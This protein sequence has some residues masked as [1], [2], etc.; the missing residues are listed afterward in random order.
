[1]TTDPTTTPVQATPVVV[2]YTNRDFYSLRDDLITRVKDRV[3]VG[4]TSKWYGNDPADFGVAL[5][6]SFAYMGDIIG[7]YIDR[8]AN[9]SNILTATQR[10]SIY[11][12]AIA[13]GYTP[14]GY[15]SATCTVQFINTT[16]NLTL[17]P[18]PVGTQ[19]SGSIVDGDTTRRVIFTT[20]QEA[21]FTSTKSV[22][23]VT[24]STPGSGYVQY[25][26]DNSSG[27]F[28]A[29]HTVT[30]TGVSPSGYNVTA[31]PIVSATSTAIVVA[32]A[33]TG[34]ATLSSAS[35]L[36]YVSPVSVTAEHGEYVSLRDGNA[37][38]PLISGDVAG[39][40][41]GTSDGTPFQSFRLKD[42]SVVQG[43]VS[44]QVQSG[45][46]YGTWA[47]VTHLM[48]YGPADSVYTVYTDSNNNTY[49]R[50]GDGVSGAIPNMYSKIKVDYLSGG[51]TI[52]NIPV[53]TLTQVSKAPG[54]SNLSPYISNLTTSNTTVGTGGADPESLD[55]IRAN[56]P[57]VAATNSR[58][59]T[60]ADYS[61]LALG[62]D[63]VGKANATSS[64]WSSVTLYVAPRRD[65]N[66][67]DVYPG[68][69]DTNTA[70]T[71]EWT[72]IQ[73]DVQ[74]YMA[75][76]LQI[77]VSLTI[78]A[79]TY[80]DVSLKMSYSK[81]PEFSATQVE[82]SIKS[83]LNSYYSYYVATFAQTI[84]PEDIEFLLK[85]VPGIYNVRVTSLVRSGESDLRGTLVGN[86]GE[87]F[88]FKSSNIVL[89]ALGT[90]ATLAAL[91][92]TN[93]STFIPTFA[94]GTLDY[95]TTLTSGTSTEIT[96]TP[97]STSGTVVRVSGG[98]QTNTVTYADATSAPVTVSIPVGTT[99]F[100]IVVTAEDGTT[101]KTYTL[102]VTRA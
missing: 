102:T 45:T 16:A 21:D 23:A 83:Y 26:L 6:E 31:E 74:T 98:G 35:A 62:V 44:V 10:N 71:S 5:I 43:T 48:D 1:M 85:Y 27:A 41:V 49:V 39:E 89:T 75:D 90:T 56:A 8:I 14:S 52:G 59:I 42:S 79:P 78:A 18:L 84:Y 65:I 55:S 76:K 33:T 2:D 22:T 80:S 88:I 92:A 30:I 11:N 86:P 63:T 3:N 66:S 69:N 73:S 9:E 94:S 77:G 34:T 24:P 38:D 72:S 97:T 101:T 95:A 87:I 20:T 82:D 12:L 64:I 54:I 17:S 67:S 19:L 37:A 57:Q 32:N 7:Y 25:T 99:V 13:Y 51:G 93:T 15:K 40:L 50:F 60:L 28:V 68:K 81:F 29:G 58:A 46:S 53:N 100:T 96:T 61:S 36:T 91:T 47:E 4:S 70:T